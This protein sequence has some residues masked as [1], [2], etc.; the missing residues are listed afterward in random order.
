M[1]RDERATFYSQR[2]ARFLSGE[3]GV[4]ADTRQ[5]RFFAGA[6]ARNARLKAS[7]GEEE[8]DEDYWDFLLGDNE[9]Q[10]VPSLLLQHAEENDGDA[11]D[12]NGGDDDPSQEKRAQDSDASGALFDAAAEGLEAPMELGRKSEK[13]ALAEIAALDAALEVAVNASMECAA[14]V[15][16]PQLSRKDAVVRQPGGKTRLGL[17]SL[18]RFWRLWLD[19][20]RI[21]S[22]EAK[23]SWEEVHPRAYPYVS[24]CCVSVCTC[25]CQCVIAACRCACVVWEEEKREREGGRQGGRVGGE[26]TCVHVCM[27]CMGSF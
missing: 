27:C 12:D 9:L 20:K 14:V 15:T 17:R 3:P 21:E 18:T 4:M 23:P 11:S 24:A 8:P 5:V 26:R 25:M 6:R 2:V 10:I 19:K 22:D 13:D 16:A 7:R 1:G